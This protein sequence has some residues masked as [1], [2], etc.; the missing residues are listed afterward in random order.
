M[1]THP[2]GL[3]QLAGPLLLWNQWISSGL[4]LSLRSFQHPSPV[5]PSPV[6]GESYCWEML[7]PASASSTVKRTWFGIWLLP[8]AAQY[9]TSPLLW[10]PQKMFP[11]MSEVCPEKGTMVGL[12]RRRAWRLPVLGKDSNRLSSQVFPI[13][14]HLPSQQDTNIGEA[15]S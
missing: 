14:S 5:L 10:G 9:A 15:V 1:A 8:S 6:W 11:S 2:W 3:R 13:I 4:V 7:G 12:G